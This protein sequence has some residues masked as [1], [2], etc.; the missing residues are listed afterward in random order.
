VNAPALLALAGDLY[1]QIQQLVAENA[2]LKDELAK[3]E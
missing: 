1:A 2:K 3:T